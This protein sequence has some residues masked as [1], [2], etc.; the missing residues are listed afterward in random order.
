[1][2]NNDCVLLVEGQDDLHVVRQ[3]GA[4]HQS[5]PTFCIRAKGG[6]DNLLE[7]IGSEILV[8][9]RKVVGIL[10]DANGNLDARW[11]AVKNRLQE[12]NIIV[13][14]HPEPTGTIININNRPRIGIWLMPDNQSTGELEDF[15]A[16]MIPD[17]DP[18]WPRSKRYIDSIPESD[19]KFSKKKIPR[20]QVH[21]WLATRESPRQMGVAIRAK[22]L[23]T[24]GPLSTTFADWLRE[25]FELSA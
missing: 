17:S 11:T 6:I 2:P 22:D 15:V 1:M 12:E 19:Q 21:A 14:P 23:D 25:L 8:P 16:E 13:P 3:F 9:A 5:M 20:A 4:S 10:V 18:V 7:E 24:S